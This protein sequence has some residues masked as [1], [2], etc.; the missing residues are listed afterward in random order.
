MTSAKESIGRFVQICEKK[1]ISQIVFS[2]GSRNAPLIIGFTS[3][4]SFNCLNIPDERVAAFFALGMA[5]KLREPVILCCTSGSA[6]LNYA[7][8]VV[9]AFY[10]RV[11]LLILSADRPIEW[12]DQGAG[13]TMRQR[14]AF[15][16]YILGSFEFIQEPSDYDD[17]W[18]NDRIASQAIDLCNGLPQGPVHVNVPF[19]E[20]LYDTVSVL[21]EYP[22]V[23]ETLRTIPTLGDHEA[24]RIVDAWNT[25]EQILVLCGQMEYEERLSKLLEKLSHQQGIVVL[26]EM[27]SNVRGSGIIQCIDRTIEGISNEELQEYCP[28][29]LISMGGAIVSKRIRFLLRKMNIREH[30]L[31]DEKEKHIDTYQALTM[32]VPIA[33]VTFFEMVSGT[34][35]SEERGA[36]FEKWHVL[37][38]NAAFKHTGY[39]AKCTWSDLKAMQVVLN[40]LPDNSSVHAANSTPVRYI[41]LFEQRFDINY[42]SNRGVS[43]IDGCTS[44]AAGHA[45]V[46]DRIV[47]LIT[48]DIAFFYDSNAFWHHHVPYNLRIIL[49]NNGGG[50]IFRYIPGPSETPVLETQ[51]EAAHSTNAKGL[52][53]SYD[54]DY[55]RAHNE[56][57]LETALSALYAPNHSKRVR[58]IEV[59]T[60]S[61]VNDRVLRSYFEAL[62]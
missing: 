4:G 51:F 60:P 57:E 7:P 31:I 30:W 27:T 56:H 35:D 36:F 61:T 34:K 38:E 43:G 5:L 48:G 53:D 25:H 26:S 54:L 46:V 58:L 1:G 14:D 3:H 20:P 40:A 15:G 21:S 59:F 9:E 10:Q 37:A 47:T 49:I 11:P 12:I 41:Q 2:P 28:T 16:R 24:K 62:K 8:A 18:Y 52:A 23:I 32:N 39:L 42:Y 55:S 17:F 22:K 6:L 45:Y 50:G 33:P 44:T 19:R 13:Q 29:L